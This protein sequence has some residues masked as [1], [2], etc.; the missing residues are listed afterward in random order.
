MSQTEKVIVEVERREETGKNEARRLRAAG[1]IPGNVYGLDRP[2]FKVAINPRRLIQVLK[3]ES[4]FN[5]VFSLALSG[6]ERTREAMLK[7]IQRDP[8]SGL[9]LHVDFVRVD[10]TRKLTVRVP[11]QLTGTPVGVKIEGGI[12]DFVHREIDVECLPGNIPEHMDVDISELHINQHVSV[13]DLQGAADVEIKDDP[14]QILAVIVAPRAEE[15][16]AVEEEEGA[17]DVEAEAGTAE[18]EAGGEPS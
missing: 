12:V 4:G 5:T 17:E 7:E 18:K 2:P 1:R 10:A 8:L 6:E 11:V 15:T 16:E 9:P 14:E 3:L 13:K